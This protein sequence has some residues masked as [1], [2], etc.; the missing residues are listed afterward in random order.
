MINEVKAVRGTFVSVFHN[1]SL[2]NANRWTGFRE[3]FNLI[4]ESLD[5]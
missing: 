5:D 2:G 4:L 1:Y 3:L